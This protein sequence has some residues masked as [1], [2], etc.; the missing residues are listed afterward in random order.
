MGYYRRNVYCTLIKGFEFEWIFSSAAMFYAFL[1]AS[2]V[3][4]C[5]LTVH[6]IGIGYKRIVK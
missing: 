5:V 1:V 4:T 3:H 2:I 6:S